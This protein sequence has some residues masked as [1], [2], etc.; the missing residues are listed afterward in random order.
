MSPRYAVTSCTV[1]AGI[2]MCVLAGT[3][4][5]HNSSVGFCCAAA[6]GPRAA[7]ALSHDRFAFAASEHCA[8]KTG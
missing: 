7:V 3:L 8:A 6:V 5:Q 1:A 4:L 2:R